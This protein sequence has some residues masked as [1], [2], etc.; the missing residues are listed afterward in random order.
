M[1][2]EIKK[3]DELIENIKYNLQFAPRELVEELNKRLIAVQEWFD[4]TTD[5]LCAGVLCDLGFEV[6]DKAG[7]KITKV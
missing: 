5:D 3:I 1:E 6:Q 4:E 7:N 2:N